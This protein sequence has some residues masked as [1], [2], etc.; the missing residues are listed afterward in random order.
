MAAIATTKTDYLTISA[1]A[2][3]A[4]RVMPALQRHGI[5]KLDLV[6]DLE[7][8]HS[9][10][11]LQLEALLVANDL[12]FCHDV[13]GIN[14]HLNRETGQLGGWFLPRFAQRAVAKGHS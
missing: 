2:D 4:L 7:A 3:R 9:W 8:T 13:L 1:I 12:D 10:C 5:V 11:P 14:R 6:M